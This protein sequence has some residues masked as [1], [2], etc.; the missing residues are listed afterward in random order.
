M[1]PWQVGV[2]T[3][4]TVTIL[5]LLFQKQNANMDS[6]FDHSKTMEAA[7]KRKN[8]FK[9]DNVEYNETQ[10]METKITKALLKKAIDDHADYHR[11]KPFPHAVIDDLFPQNLLKAADLEIVDDPVLRVEGCAES[12]S[13]C[14]TKAEDDHR[15][16]FKNAFTDDTHFGPAT[17]KLFGILKSSTFLTFLETLTN[18]PGLIPDPHYR[19]SGIHQTLPGGKLAVHA[20]FNQYEE[21]GLHRRVNVF[22]YLNPDWEESY[23]GHLELWSRDL[24]SCEQRIL[25]TMG[26]FVVF[27]STDFSYHG[28]SAPLSCPKGRSRRSL[29]MYYYTTSRPPSEC[30]NSNCFSKHSTLWQKTACPTCEERKC[31]G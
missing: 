22:I 15:Q 2:V 7:I 23:G 11:K 20:D 8:I 17:S 27:S 26:R 9:K 1:R 25:P 18:I 10:G 24:K 29:A 6:T 4:V 13:A 31:N 30:I 28:H 19:G 12:S 16:H 5:L 21:Y 14:F 3:L